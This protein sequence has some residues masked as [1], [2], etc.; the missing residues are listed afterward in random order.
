M[1]Q[2]ACQWRQSAGHTGEQGQA[3]SVLESADTQ[4]K[5]VSVS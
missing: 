3:E 2:D 1:N 5:K 4:M